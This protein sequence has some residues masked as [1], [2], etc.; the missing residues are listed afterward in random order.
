MEWSDLGICP[1]SYKK[2][3]QGWE[4]RLMEGSILCLAKKKKEKRKAEKPAKKRTNWALS[5]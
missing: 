4:N 1:K 3:L 2:V 5:R